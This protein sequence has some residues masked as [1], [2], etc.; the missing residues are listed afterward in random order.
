MIQI[1]KKIQWNPPQKTDV[2]I[3]DITGSKLLID[4]ILKD[5]DHGVLPV[6]NEV[7]YFHP[8]ILLKVIKNIKYRD[9][10]RTRKWKSCL[11]RSY[12]FSCLEYTNPKIV[13]TYIDNDP[14]FQWL[15]KHYK[16]AVFYALQNGFR[17]KTDLFTCLQKPDGTIA[18]MAMPNFL[19]FGMCD[20]ENYKKYGHSIAVAH[21][22]GSLKGSY[23]KYGGN[24]GSG[25]IEYEICLVSQYRPAIFK[26]NNTPNFRD[27]SIKVHSLLKSYLEKN[28]VRA[29]VAL[30][31]FAGE[32][33][34]EY[35]DA[36]FGSLV[37]IIRQNPQNYMSTYEA[38][39]SS[40]VVL[41]LNS[42]A[43]L[44]AFGW[45]KKVLFCNFTG[46]EI[47][48]IFFHRLCSVQN[49]DSNEFESILNTL[50]EMK[51]EEY[52]TLTE[53][54]R[55]YVMNYNPDLPVNEY[56]RNIIINTLNKAND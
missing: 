56:M 44:E 40:E 27:A 45:G 46:D 34:Y 8:R 47:A 21:C 33:E 35:Y 32:E 11:F 10:F 24:N 37:T 25:K 54:E 12:L 49:A 26:T 41:A 14:M 38:M 22:V 31:A 1:L 6:R 20:V 36:F 19:C 5:I 29:C 17:N 18:H 51:N 9:L 39:D 30:S 16:N 43:A 50:L 42:T 3:F 28:G 4:L 53:K 48:D 2:L 13:L 23:Y 55:R 7:W 52:L 15:S